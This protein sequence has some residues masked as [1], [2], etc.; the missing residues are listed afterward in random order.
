ML[1]RKR[2]ATI[3]KTWSVSLLIR[4][5][6]VISTGIC[7]DVCFFIFPFYSTIEVFYWLTIEHE[8]TCSFQST[9]YLQPW[10]TEGNELWIYLNLTSRRLFIFCYN[11]GGLSLA[12]PFNM[13]EIHWKSHL[14]SIPPVGLYMINLTRFVNNNNH[15]K[16]AD[17]EV[18]DR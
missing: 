18:I 9:S 14:L 13:Y 4:K 3:N 2:S 6:H 1:K 17:S 8:W 5:S 12:A 16:A 7:L 11:V 15:P 10:I